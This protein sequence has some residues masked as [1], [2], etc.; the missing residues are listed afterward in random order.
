MIRWILSAVVLLVPVA[1]SIQPAAAAASCNQLTGLNAVKSYSGTAGTSY[2]SGTLVGPPPPALGADEAT[3]SVDRRATNLQ[4]SDLRPGAVQGAD[5]GSSTQ[6][7][8]GS[9]TVNDSYV[10]PTTQ[11]D[12]Q[13]TASGPTKA[14]GDGNG[15]Q[16][17]TDATKCT[18]QVLVSFGIDTT[19]TGT[20]GDPGVADN[21]TSPSEPIP[22]NLELKGSATIPASGDGAAAG[23]AGLF[24]MSGDP[25][26]GFWI[27]YVTVGTPAGTATVS[28][29]LNPAGAKAG[30]VVPKLAGMKQSS[31]EKALTAAG[32][33]V[34]KLSKTTSSKVAKGKVISSK[35]KAGTKLNTGAKVALVV[36]AG[37]K[38]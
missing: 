13:Q 11:D 33:K 20:P 38:K 30:C 24:D 14:G 25:V 17:L 32:C 36:S 21:A 5:F 3:I 4:I 6:P 23:A 7:T 29:D 37:K 9:V 1:F 15:V 19:T 16:I 27:D 28:W 31:A 34:G 22:A 26:Y 2:V 35:P 18:Y 12:T 8:G 10:D